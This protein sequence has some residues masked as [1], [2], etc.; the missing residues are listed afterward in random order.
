MNSGQSQVPASV[1]SC[2]TVPTTSVDTSAVESISLGVAQHTFEQGNLDC[3]MQCADE[4]HTLLADLLAADFKQ[5]EGL[6]P[7]IKLRPSTNAFMHSSSYVAHIPKSEV[8]AIYLYIDGGH[9]TAE[10]T[11]YETT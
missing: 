1:V 5:W 3:L 8:T 7:A 4:G 11:T 10:D 9:S 6:P 2:C